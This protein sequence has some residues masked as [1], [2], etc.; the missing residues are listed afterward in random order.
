[1]KITINIFKKPLKNMKRI[2]LFLMTEKGL[3]VLRAFVANVGHEHVAFVVS[4]QDGNVKND[5]Y[6]EI[7]SLCKKHNIKFYNRDHKILPASDYAFAIS[8]RWLIKDNSRLITLHDS[9]LPKYRGFSPLPTALINGEK[10]VG[11]TAFL[12]NEEFD[13]GEIVGQRKLK[14][15]YPA[16]IQKVIESISKEYGKLVVEIASKIIAGKK[17][18]GRKQNDKAVTYSLWRDEDDYRINWSKDAPSI[19]RLVDAVGYPYKGASSL[20]DGHMVRIIEATAEPDVEIEDRAVGKVIF[21][22]N[23]FPIIVCGSGLLKVTE[24]T[25][26]TGENLLPLKKFRSRFV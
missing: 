20:L 3:E 17:L 5:Y 18:P 11:V 9:L 4:A 7:S 6:K 22:R 16:K 1:M 25:D 12:V 19:E 13:A 24:L 15:H 2:G 14:I 8:W 10:H 26:D 21:I 23:G